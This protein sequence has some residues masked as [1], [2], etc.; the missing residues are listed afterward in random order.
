MNEGNN[1]NSQFNNNQA[2]NSTRPVTNKF[3]PADLFDNDI[4][5]VNS[6]MTSVADSEFI[7]NTTL[8][9]GNN[10]INNVNR[11]M[12]PQSPEVLDLF[13]EGVETLMDDVNATTYSANMP[14][15]M[16]NVS[17]PFNNPNMGVNQPP[18]QNQQMV[19]ND[20]TQAWMDSQPLSMGGLGVNTIVGEDAPKEIVEDNKFIQSRD[21]NPQPNQIKPVQQ[22]VDNSSTIYNGFK[23]PLPEI[24][25]VKVNKEYVGEAFTKITMAPFSFVGLL[26]GGLYLI[27]RKVYLLGLIALGFEFAIF[28]LIPVPF[29]FVGFFVYRLVLALLVNRLYLGDAKSKVKHLRK[30]NPKK[31]QYEL[32]VLAKKK[33]GTNMAMALL[34]GFIYMSVLVGLGIKFNWQSIL[35]LLPQNEEPVINEDSEGVT[36]YNGDLTYEDYDILNNFN[37]I[38]PGEFKKEGQYYTYVYRVPLPVEEEPTEDKEKDKDKETEVDNNEEQNTE[39]NTEENNNTSQKPK[40]KYSNNK[41]TLSFNAVKGYK[42]EEDLIKS[43]AYYYTHSEDEGVS[44]TTNNGLEWQVFDS[45]KTNEK[46]YFRV[47]KKDDKLLLFVYKMEYEDENKVCESYYNNIYN[48]ISSK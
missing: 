30:H 8:G 38:I 22:V 11:P 46:I 3:F 12:N 35:N 19:P 33:G 31:N 10:D 9:T 15:Q 42:D 39:E 41:C 5:Q 18:E 6:S 25:E 23:E 17:Q 37:I 20:G 13:D 4:N 7:K 24:D 1:F 34:V 40:V 32:S 43:I 27:Y 45:D 16:N 48:S 44:K 29:S 14:N 47:T 36:G 21:Y 28:F 2:N 26:F